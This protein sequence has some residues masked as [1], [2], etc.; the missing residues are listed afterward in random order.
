MEYGWVEWM[1]RRCSSGKDDPP[2][3][4][5]R[6]P[7]SRTQ[8]NWE[9]FAE[10]DPMSAILY[11]DPQSPEWT[12][13]DFFQSGINHCRS[14]MEDV[15]IPRGVPENRERALDFGCGMGRL[16][17]GLSGYFGEVVGVDISRE[18]LRLAA[19][20]RKGQNVRFIHNATDHLRVFD[21]DSFDLVLSMIV[22][23]HIPPSAS[24]NYIREFIR[25]LKPGGIA[26]F[27]LPV[28]SLYVDRGFTYDL[29]NYIS[30]R[31]PYNLWN[32]IRRIAYRPK[33]ILELRSRL[34]EVFGFNPTMEVRGIPREEL[35]HHIHDC[36]GRLI[37]TLDDF[38]TGDEIQSFLYLVA[39]SPSE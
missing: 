3:T 16:T 6:K 17:N 7:L 13:E 5:V 29:W 34:P 33:R 1:K 4:G 20:H 10:R 14:L 24:L 25:I 36:N 31:F 27:Q 26:V 2:K 28:Q 35:V 21:D 22:L 39:T 30:R 11:R 8:K 18:M 37:E 12:A 23:Q 38:S 9:R 32:E 15:L 19:E